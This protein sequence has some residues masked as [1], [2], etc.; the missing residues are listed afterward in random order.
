MLI[1]TAGQKKAKEFGYR[2]RAFDLGGLGFGDR[3]DDPRTMSRFRRVKS[4]MK[5][6]LIASVMAETTETFVTWIDGDATLIRSIDEISEENSWDVGVTV[7]PKR[8]KKKTHYINAGVMFFRSNNA[9]W[10]FVEEWC[11]EMPPIPDL[12]SN[13][14]PVN[15]SDQQTLEENILLQAI[16]EPLW[17]LV[18]QVREVRGCKVKFFPCEVYNNFWCIKA[19]YYDH[20]PGKAKIIH[21]KGHRMHRIDDYHERFLK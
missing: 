16:N 6:E 20:G 8:E 2:F 5:P 17:D 3:I 9:S 10:R 7:R 13:E 12:T 15:Y 14:K 18:G 11:Q 19:P 1:V 21:F 4:A